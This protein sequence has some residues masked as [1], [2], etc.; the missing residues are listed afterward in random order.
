MQSA[1]DRLGHLSS[2]R[3]EDV[4]RRPEDGRA[5]PLATNS[6]DP[7]FERVR[8]HPMAGHFKRVEPSQA[9]RDAGARLG[10]DG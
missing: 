2:G 6:S 7:Y 10:L 5:F 9:A 8:K 1:L 4:R 3:K